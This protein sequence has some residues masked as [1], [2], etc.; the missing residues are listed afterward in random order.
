VSF[1]RP[2]GGVNVAQW[3][4]QRLARRDLE[5]AKT[6]MRSAIACRLPLRSSMAAQKRNLALCV[7]NARLAEKFG[8]K[9]GAPKLGKYRIR[10]REPERLPAA[11]GA[12]PAGPGLPARAP[13]ARV[14]RPGRV[15]DL[16]AACPGRAGS[17]ET[18]PLHG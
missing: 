2:A 16:S 14:M 7:A 3:Y 4:S 5:E 11:R 17:R 6:C 9:L 13:Q 1:V 8:G 18:E 12:G 10:A 15:H